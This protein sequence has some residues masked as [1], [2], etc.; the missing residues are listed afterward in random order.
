MRCIKVHNVFP[1][2]LLLSLDFILWFSW[3]HLECEPLLWV[4]AQMRNRSH[5][6]LKSKC[7]KKDFASTWN[8]ID[9]GNVKNRSLAFIPSA[10][11]CSVTHSLT[12]SLLLLLFSQPKVKN[13]NF[14]LWLIWDN[15]FSN[16]TSV[17]QKPSRTCC[18]SFILIIMEILFHHNLHWEWIWKGREGGRGGG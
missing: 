15:S 14:I 10:F 5:T 13:Q 12:Q 2:L 7:I 16:E 11:I 3:Q 9:F 18:I 8:A 4:R 17:V 1:L 6:T